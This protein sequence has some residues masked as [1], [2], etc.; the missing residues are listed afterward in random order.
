MRKVLQVASVASMID[1]FNRDNINILTGAGYHVDVAANFSFGSTSSQEKVDRLKEELE[2]NKIN[3]FNIL[4]DRSVISLSNIRAYRE[5]K[6]IIN[7]NSYDFIHCHSPIGGVITRLAARK[8]RKTGTQVIYTAHGFHFFK[9]ASWINW[10]VYFPIEYFF[11]FF[12][13]ILITIN[14]EDFTL[15][16]RVMK[17]KQVY[18]VPG[19]GID[20]DK[21]QST[22]VDVTLKRQSIGIPEEA[23]MLLS[24]GEINKNK[25]HE[26]IIRAISKLNNPTIHYCIVGRGEMKKYLANLA[27]ELDIENQIHFLGFREDIAELCKVSDIFCFPSQREGLGLAAIEAMATGL[28]LVTSNIHGINDY[29]KN[30]LSGYKCNP[31]SVNEFSDAIKLLINDN[32]LRNNIG[33]YN[34]REAWNYDIKKIRKEMKRIYFQSKEIGRS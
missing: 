18:Y 7:E 12:T 32:H 1:Q 15:A 8:A 28:P 3:V 19:V 34:S 10:L 16:K 9:G 31:R 14:Q 23:I 27:K 33:N 22:V 5:L 2:S 6:K 25:N 4:F 30:S 21:F 13:D 20:V 11:S 17:S 29:S 26:V 24:I